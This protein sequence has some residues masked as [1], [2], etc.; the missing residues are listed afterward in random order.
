ML[1][2]LLAVISSM[3][4]SVTMRLSVGRIHNDIGMLSVSYFTCM[5]LTFAYVYPIGKVSGESGM[6]TALI[7]GMTAG[8]L[9][10]AGFMML[11][12]NIQTNGVVLSATFAKLGVV[13]PT[14]VSILFFGERMKVVQAAGFLLTL[15]AIWL[16]NGEKDRGNADFKTGLVLLLLVNGVADA[17]AKIYEELGNPLL[18]DVYLC[19]TFIMASMLSAVLAFRKKEHIGVAEVRWGILLGIPNYY[20]V[21]FIMKALAEIPAVITYPTYSVATIA[22][23][24][25]VGIIIFREKLSRKQQAAI[26]IIAVAIAL[27]NI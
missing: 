13:V 12:I 3:M 11:Q 10:L 24:T 27:L 9:L 2:L 4:V 1:Y 5:L 14:V 19:I 17:M 16:V 6:G 15:T 26:G 20:S 22:A 8:I 21:R 23:I 18:K 25:V 7:L